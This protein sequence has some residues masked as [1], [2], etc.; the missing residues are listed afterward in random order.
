[1]AGV[2]YYNPDEVKT[3]F[4]RE[5]NKPNPAKPRASL[6]PGKVVILLAGR[7]KGRRVVLL[8]R[9]ESGLWLVTGPYKVNGVPLRRVNQAYVQ[10]TSTTVKVDGVDVSKIDDKY[11]A[12]GKQNRELS[13][14]TA[15][16]SLDKELSEE[17]KKRLQSKKETQSKVDEALLKEIKNTE[18]LERYLSK[19]FSLRK[20]MRPH[21][22]NF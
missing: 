22:M 16:A 18:L 6:A 5:R 4:R 3:H 14:N 19:R 8:K 13:K 20:N 9:L 12:K 1:M 21:D 2:N 17:D 15:W 7:F 11:F 10:P